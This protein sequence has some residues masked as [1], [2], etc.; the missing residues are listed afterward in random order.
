MSSPREHVRYITLYERHG[1][2]VAATVRNINGVLGEDTNSIATVHRWF[3][4]YKEGDTS[5]KDEPRPGRL[6]LSTTP[7]FSISSK[8]IRK[9]TFSRQR[10]CD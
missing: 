6:S 5:F 10:S 8:R 7:S 2:G 4:L 1:T 3:A 9:V